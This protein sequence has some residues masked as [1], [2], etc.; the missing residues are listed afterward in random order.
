M[1]EDQ[2]PESG[3]GVKGRA[4][5]F[6]FILFFAASVVGT[7]FFGLDVVK[8]VKAQAI[9]SDSALRTTGYAILVATSTDRA[10][11]LEVGEISDLELPERIRGSLAEADPDSDTSWPAS[12]EAAMDGLEPMTLADALKLVQVSWPPERDLP[13]VLSVG[14]RPSGMVDAKPTLDVVNGWLRNA[15]DRLAN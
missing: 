3:K 5:L 10:F 9:R 6:G 12:L 4:F 11:P 8:N 14:G 7:F 2:A 1:I 15:G 13:P